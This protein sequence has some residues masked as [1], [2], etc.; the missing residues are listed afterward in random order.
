MNGV[1]YAETYLSNNEEKL[2]IIYY[3]IILT[4]IY[5]TLVKEN[6]SKKIYNKKSIFYTIKSLTTQI[7]NIFSISDFL[8]SAQRLR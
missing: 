6:K 5:E 8:I 7:L 4:S 2:F 3:W 1:R